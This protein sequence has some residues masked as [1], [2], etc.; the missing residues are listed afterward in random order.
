[1]VMFN[2]AEYEQRMYQNAEIKAKIKYENKVTKL[3]KLNCKPLFNYLKSKSVLRKSVERLK[4]DDGSETKSP[5]ETAEVLADF[6]QSVFKPEPFGPLPQDCY[7]KCN[8]DYFWSKFM[9]HP[10]SV[11]KILGSLDIS[12]AMGPDGVHP[13]LLRYLSENSSFV[14]AVV[15]LFLIFIQHYF[16]NSNLRMSNETR[17]PQTMT[18]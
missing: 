5:S 15:L 4:T 16:I 8:N 7:T 9:V 11:A 3:F 18:E 2:A 10:E 14:D 12:K 1:M 13:R 6:F 17:S